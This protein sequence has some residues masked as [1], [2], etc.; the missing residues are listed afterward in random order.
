MAPS[1]TRRQIFLYSDQEHC[2]SVFGNTVLSFSLQPPNPQF[3]EAWTAAVERLAKRSKG[4]ISVMTIVDGRCPPPGDAA[5]AAIRDTV[6]R[7]SREIGAFA[8]VI[9]GDGFGAAAVRSAVTMIGL[10][11]RYP[12]PQKVFKDA[13]AAC[14]WMIDLVPVS[15]PTKTGSDMLSAVSMMRSAVQRLAATG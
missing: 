8:Y 15:D 2:L 11:A 5:K 14:S 3:L 4:P 9:E 13:S 6:V 1:S 12:F 7:Y 10:V